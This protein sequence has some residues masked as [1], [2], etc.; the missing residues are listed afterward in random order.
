MVKLPELA[1]ECPKCK[2]SQHKKNGLRR[3]KQSYRCKDCGYQFVENPIARGYSVE[4]KELCLKMYLN[5]MGFRAIARVTEIDHG[6]IINWVREKG[7]KLSD[8]PQEEEIPEIT[9]IDEL[10]TFVG[11]KKNKFWIWTVVNHWQQGIL[12]WTIGDRSHQTFER[13]WQIIKFWR[14]FWYVTDGWKVYPMYI[15]PE[16]HLVSKTYMTRVEGENTRLRHYLARLHRKT[17]C[18][19][20]SLDMLKYSIRLLLF[21]LRFKTIP[22]SV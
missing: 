3:G 1:M 5:G 17:L 7:E 16:D 11:C 18:Y 13:I 19:S 10:Q 20:K 4:I 2:S 22:A 21:Y 14:S 9:E 12:L 15:Q 6:T 8:E